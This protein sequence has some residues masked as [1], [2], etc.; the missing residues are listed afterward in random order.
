ME[1]PKQTCCGVS[2]ASTRKLDRFANIYSGSYKSKVQKSVI[3]RKECIQCG[4]VFYPSF[5]RNGTIRQYTISNKIFS[6][7]RETYFSTEFLDF[8]NAL[9]VLGSN[10]F[11]GIAEIFNL[12]SDIKLCAKRIEDAF[13]VYNMALILPNFTYNEVRMKNRELDI[14]EMMLSIYPSARNLFLAK[15]IYHSCSVIGCKERYLV[16][17]GNEKR[18]R[19]ICAEGRQDVKR[20]DQGLPNIVLKCINVPDIKNGSKYCKDH[21]KNNKRTEIERLDVRITRSM[22]VDTVIRIEGECRKD[23]NVPKYVQRTA[24]MFYGFRPCGYRVFSME[25]YTAESLSSVF[26]ALADIF[27]SEEIKELKGLVY[28]R[29]C[30]LSKTVTKM[31]QKGNRVAENYSKLDY[32]V[33]SFHI[34]GHTEPNCMKEHFLKLDKYSHVKGM[35]TLAAEQGFS[36][37]NKTNRSTRPMTYCRRLV[38]MLVIDDLFNTSLDDKRK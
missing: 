30:G 29:A 19:S 23:S 12:G 18:F 8:V 11:D 25:M 22:N 33:D 1:H 32:I 38:Y 37:L 31:A 2:L 35:N 13:L 14:E 21:F 6:V 20:L 7:T 24:G 26:V 5:C 16:I 4:M 3:F 10:T 36:I 34:K 9:V 15:S 17:D 27:G 28:D